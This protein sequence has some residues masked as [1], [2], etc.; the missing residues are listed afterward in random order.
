MDMNKAKYDLI[1]YL[2]SMCDSYYCLIIQVY[3]SLELFYG[4]FIQKISQRRFKCN[5]GVSNAGAVTAVAFSI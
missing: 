2:I 5:R 3:L 4:H 1:L